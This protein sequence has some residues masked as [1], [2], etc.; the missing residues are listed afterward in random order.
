[1]QKHA[2]IGS[3][4]VLSRVQTSAHCKTDRFYN[5]RLLFEVKLPNIDLIYIG[6]RL[7]SRVAVVV[8]PF[9]MLYL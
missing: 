3:L 6:Y 5:D 9:P 2:G 4:T 1:M 7:R 8:S